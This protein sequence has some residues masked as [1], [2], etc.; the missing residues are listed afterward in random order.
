MCLA[1][2]TLISPLASA[3][4]TPASIPVAV[5]TDSQIVSDL[6]GRVDSLAKELAVPVPAP[7]NARVVTP[8][9]AAYSRNVNAMSAIRRVLVFNET[10]ANHTIIPTDPFHRAT[11]DHQLASNDCKLAWT[12]WAYCQGRSDCLSLN[13]WDGLRLWA[14]LGSRLQKT[15]D[16]LAAL[17]PESETADPVGIISLPPAISDRLKHTGKGRKSVLDR[18]AG[19][20]QLSNEERSKL[21]VR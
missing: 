10:L 9:M 14:Q 1:A 16:E 3:E 11:R 20:D 17:N 15:T 21:I 19:W 6:Q 7:D 8:A 5:L 2:F 13:L 18:V 4:N 12:W